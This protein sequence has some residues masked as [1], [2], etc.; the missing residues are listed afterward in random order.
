M[1]P[2]PN[3]PTLD[4]ERIVAPT[5]V[6]ANTTVKAL[7]DRANERIHLYINEGNR[8]GAAASELPRPREGNPIGCE[9]IR[10]FTPK[11]AR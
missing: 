11:E 10:Q 2:E 4:S 6:T 1:P 7:I 9:G 5:I 3:W 8:R